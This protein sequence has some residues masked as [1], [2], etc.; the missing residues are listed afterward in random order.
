MSNLATLGALRASSSAPAA[1]VGEI[2][3]YTPPGST[4]SS[5]AGIALAGV[6]VVG[7][8][9]VGVWMWNK[10]EERLMK[11]TPEQRHEEHMDRLKAGVA[12]SLL[13]KF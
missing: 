12:Y 1:A 10:D 6:V 5:T 8:I 9:G 13:S 11:L 3:T 7:I 4:D 2:T